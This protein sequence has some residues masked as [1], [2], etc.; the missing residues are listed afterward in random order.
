VLSERPGALALAGAGLVLT[1][2]A[3]LALPSVRRSPVRMA[4]AEAAG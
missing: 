3:L 4:A 1:G 2:L